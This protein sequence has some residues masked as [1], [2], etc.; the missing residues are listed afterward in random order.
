MLQLEGRAR[1]LRVKATE[2]KTVIPFRAVLTGP[3][4][5]SGFLNRKKTK[6]NIFSKNKWTNDYVVLNGTELWCYDDQF[7]DPANPTATIYLSTGSGVPFEL[8]EIGKEKKKGGSGSD[9]NRARGELYSWTIANPGI[10]HILKSSSSQ[11]AKEWVEAIQKAQNG[12][13]GQT[14]YS[15]RAALDAVQL[16]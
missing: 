12:K 11:E 5:K 3:I 1:S 16:N 9:K 4:T 14:K 6:S 15:Q 13:R 7:S 8:V 2:E 10:T